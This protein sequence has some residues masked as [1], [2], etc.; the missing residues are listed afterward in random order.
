MFSALAAIIVLLQGLS[1]V[2]AA[3]CA[4][5]SATTSLS[6]ARW[7]RESTDWL[8]S[9]MEAHGHALALATDAYRA[10]WRATL[11]KSSAGIQ[12]P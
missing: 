11:P 9:R 6:L 8:A 1:L 10:S 4:L 12:A 5:V 7:L 3:I 2:G